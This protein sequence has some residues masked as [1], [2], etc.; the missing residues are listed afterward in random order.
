MILCLDAR[1]VFSPTRRGTGKNLIDLYRRV[2]EKRPDW[3]FVMF[4]QADGPDDPFAGLANVEHRRIDI[5]GDR[6]G[7]WQ[8]VRLPLAARGAG[9]TFLHCPAN[10]APRWPLVPMIVTIHDLIFLEPEFTTPALQKLGRNVAA[11]ARKARRILTPS[12]Y[13]KGE[14]VKAFGV[15][16]DKVM[17]NPWAADAA[18]RKVTDPAE[19]NRVR[20]KYGLAED[21]PFVFGFAASDPRKNTA[22][23]LQAWADLPST[24]RGDSAIVLVGIQGSALAAFREEARRHGV[25]D[26]CLLHGFA[27]EPEVRALLSGARMLCYPSLSEGFGL[28]ILDAFACD[29]PVLTSRTTSMPEVAGDAA[30]LVDPRDASS[31]RDGLV[32]LLS[33]EAF[34]EELRRRG[35]ERLKEYTW[36]ACAERACRVFDDV[37]AEVG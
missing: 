37:Q 36:E 10:T 13:S 2:A 27:S 9:A 7:L 1:T 24:A 33:D 4:H 21:R 12:E 11:G 31:I 14:I 34:G 6:F 16:A 23:I 22:R 3:R 15:S 18:C 29:T 32:R 8:Q 20:L 17:V 19:L 5:P 28:P 26:S 30:V 35:R 25:A